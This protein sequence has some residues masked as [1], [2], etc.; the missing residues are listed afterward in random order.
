[1]KE[2]SVTIP[3]SLEK[4]PEIDKLAHQ[5]GCTAGL[6]ESACSDLAI[7]LTEIVKNAILHGNK[8]NPDKEVSLHFTIGDDRLTIIV[9][10]QGSGF[11]PDQVPDPTA[12]E[13]LLKDTGRG[14]FVSRHLLDEVH[15]ANEPG[16]MKVTLVRYL[17]NHQGQ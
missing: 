8:S 13:N 5:I 17:D 7:A 10:D 9:K 12:P 15:F 6:S 11:D 4:V 14:I 3:S 16:G 1:M 2:K